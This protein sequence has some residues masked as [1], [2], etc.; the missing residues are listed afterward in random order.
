MFLLSWNY[1]LGMFKGPR[2]ASAEVESNAAKTES[3]DDNKELSGGEEG[4]TEKKKKK[5]VGFR[6]RRVSL[7][8]NSPSI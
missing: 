4:E 2:A 1:V 8:L 7:L 3:G 5:R 6:D